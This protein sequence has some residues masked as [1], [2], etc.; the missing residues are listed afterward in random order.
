MVL[1]GKNFSKL[2]YLGKETTRSNLKLYSCSDLDKQDHLFTYD[3]PG[4]NVGNVAHLA[5]I[6]TPP[7][8]TK[9]L[10]VHTLTPENQ[11]KFYFLRVKAYNKIEVYG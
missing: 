3:I 2:S 9:L 11:S 10:L 6:S 8:S 1:G 4:S 5:Y 7:H